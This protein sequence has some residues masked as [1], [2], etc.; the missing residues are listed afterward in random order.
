MNRFPLRV[1]FHFVSFFSVHVVYLHLYRRD[2]QIFVLISRTY[3]LFSV[4][5]V[6]LFFSLAIVSVLFAYLLC[7]GAWQR[8]C[9]QAHCFRFPFRFI[10]CRYFVPSLWHIA[11]PTI[12]FFFFERVVNIHRNRLLIRH[13]AIFIGKHQKMEPIALVFVSFVKYTKFVCHNN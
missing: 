3:R 2:M 1:S 8:K 5:F 10:I 9:A 12:I 11:S 4:R 7:S 13:W 6:Y